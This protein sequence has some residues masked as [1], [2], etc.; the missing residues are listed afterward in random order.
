MMIDVSKT[1]ATALVQK[2]EGVLLLRRAK[3][4]EELPLGK[5]LWELPG[6]TVVDGEPLGAALLR[7][8]QEEIGLSLQ[9]S[10]EPQYLGA[11]V[12]T[13]EAGAIRSRRTEQVF[14]L[15]APQGWKI[16]LSP[17][18]DEH[19]FVRR[20]AEVDQLVETKELRDFLRQYLS[21]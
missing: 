20:K 14:S 1:I 9:S 3:H 15:P 12:Y 21:K 5:G 4:F 7:E 10:V 18:H 16:R 6:G 2:E 19:V 8:L 13:L 17:E 11:C